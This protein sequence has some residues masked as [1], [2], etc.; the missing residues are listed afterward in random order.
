MDL[1]PSPGFFGDAGHSPDRAGQDAARGSSAGSK[2]S[3]GA[4]DDGS[5][6]ILGTPLPAG[7][8]R[9]DA[10]LSEACMAGAADQEMIDGGV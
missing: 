6:R 10:P 3:R 1:I 5:C 4:D 8:A 7:S 2:S 9:T